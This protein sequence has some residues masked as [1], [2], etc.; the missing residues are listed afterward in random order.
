MLFKTL[1]KD[2]F[3]TLVGILLDCGGVVGPKRLGT[4]NEG[5]PIH[6]FLPVQSLDEVDLAYENT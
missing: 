3:G 6:Q 1:G 4:D 5:K 2:E